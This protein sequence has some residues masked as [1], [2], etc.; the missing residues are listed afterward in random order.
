MPH[1]SQIVAPKAILTKL[2]VTMI[3]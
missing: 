3:Y 2:H 1:D